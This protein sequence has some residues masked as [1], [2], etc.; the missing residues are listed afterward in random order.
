MTVEEFVQ[1]V[2]ENCMARFRELERSGLI[3]QPR[4]ENVEWEAPS[5]YNLR[6]INS[7]IRFSYGV[8]G[9]TERRF[10]EHVISTDGMRLSS[11]DA[12]QLTDTYAQEIG[13][14]VRNDAQTY[15]DRYIQE[16]TEETMSR[17]FSWNE[18][19]AQAAT[20]REQQR[21][22]ARN[23]PAAIEAQTAE[24]AFA[25]QR[26]IPTS[27]WHFDDIVSESQ[28]HRQEANEINLWDRPFRVDAELGERYRAS[29]N[30]TV[31]VIPPGSAY[32]VAPSGMYNQFVN[33]N[34]DLDTPAN[35]PTL[36]VKKDPA[37]TLSAL[38][39]FL[40][41]NLDIRISI[42]KSDSE[43][44]VSVAVYMKDGDESIMIASDHDIIDLD[45]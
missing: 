33:S 18:S 3:Y 13:E 39:E 45:S 30:N 14:N 15:L 20:R 16:R 12:V 4:V 26:Q 31:G 36:Q 40:K 37:I 24:R 8:V 5:R 35:P 32:R 9:T 44:D 41:E 10:L 19:P 22:I 11:V 7:C 17:A 43:V 25:Q 29:L 34:P 2:I 21:R 27:H 28:R 6:L 23:D 42:D 1:T 38:K